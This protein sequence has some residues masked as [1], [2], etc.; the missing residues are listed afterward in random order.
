M[1][2]IPKYIE[3]VRSSTKGL[4]SLSEESAKGVFKVLSTHFKKVKISIINDIGDLDQIVKAN[5]DLVFLGV[6]F[7]PLNPALGIDDDNKIWL[8]DF[9]ESYNIP[10]TGSNRTAHK[11]EKNK[12]MAKQL[13]VDAGLPTAAYKVIGKD[14]QATIRQ[15]DLEF[16]MFVKPTNR[17]G[18]MG[19]DTNSLVSNYQELNSKVEYI[20][21]KI[22][23]EA[24]IEEYLPGREFSV[25]ILREE[26]SFEYQIMPI[27]LIAPLDINEDRILSSSIKSA[28]TEQAQAIEDK[29]L[30]AEL[31]KLAEQ[32]FELLG[33][34]DYGRIDIR[35]DSSNIPNFLEANLMPSL[36]AEY[37]SFPKACVINLGLNHEAMIMRIVNLALER[38]NN[39]DIV[40]DELRV[41]A[42][43]L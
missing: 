4:S 6:E 12:P 15:L 43:V 37:G 27:E 14:Y 36:I 38:S 7:L 33:G 40:H 26:S 21:K 34:Q 42:S 18:G 9:L 16:P 2:K 25:A 29:I 10:Y 28:N 23:S 8:T 1:T 30:K 13:I 20:I 22:G 39:Q 19:V 32:V 17:G 3:I 35:L 11:F 24:L 31:S 5:P 41:R